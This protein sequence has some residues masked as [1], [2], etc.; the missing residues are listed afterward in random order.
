[1]ATNGLGSGCVFDDRESFVVGSGQGSNLWL[2][3]S[4]GTRETRWMAR[5][6]RIEYPGAVYHVMNRG[7]ARQPVFRDP[8]LGSGRVFDDRDSFIE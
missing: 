3:I 6:L 2:R 4:A 8:G 5:P 1:M 7:R